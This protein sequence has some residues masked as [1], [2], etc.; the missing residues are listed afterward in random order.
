[1]SK[2][3]AEICA[4]CGQSMTYALP[5]DKGTAD[6]VRALAI[7][8]TRKGIN[9]IHVRKEMEGKVA[10]IQ[11]GILNSN[12]V[13]NLSHARSHG[14]IAKVKDNKGNY[15]LTSKGARFLKGDPIPRIAVISKKDKRQ[16]G[17]INGETD[18]ISIK[19]FLAENEYW[20]SINFSIHEG[21]VVKDL[22]EK[23]QAMLL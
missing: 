15:C 21:H 17:Y 6:I 22:P 18:V 9:I 14:L 13:G 19:D 8:I 3:N 16:I 20:E 10:D 1:M 23:K 2:Y 12:Q 5:V 7:A 11:N 4:H